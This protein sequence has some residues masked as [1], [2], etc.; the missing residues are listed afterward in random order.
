MHMTD[1]SQWSRFNSCGAAMIID[2]VGCKINGEDD[3]YNKWGG[4]STVRWRQKA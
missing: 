2:I 1:Q 4:K 3:G